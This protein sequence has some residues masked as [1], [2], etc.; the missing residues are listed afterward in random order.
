MYHYIALSI[1]IPVIV[2]VIFTLFHA[3]IQSYVYTL[4]TAIFYGEASEDR[5]LTGADLEKKNKRRG[6]RGT[7]NAEIKRV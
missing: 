3:V 5:V 6:K 2:G 1:G 7:L 4:L